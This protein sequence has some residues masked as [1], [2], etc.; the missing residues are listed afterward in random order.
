LKID[1]RE[2]EKGI[3]S[4]LSFNSLFTG[5]STAF[6]VVATSSFFIKNLSVSQLPIAFIFSGLVGFALV[7]LY[8]KLVSWQGLIFAHVSTG[9]LFSNI[10]TVVAI[11][12]IVAMVTK[13]VRI[14]A[15]RPS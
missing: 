1:L 15:D 12:F 2:S 11:V 3:F 7:Q 5:F 13:T 10:V 14:E 6:F 8:K 9:F 4:L